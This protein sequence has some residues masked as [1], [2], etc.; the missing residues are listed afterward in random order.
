M[1]LEMNQKTLYLIFLKYTNKLIIM[2]LLLL[3][4]VLLGVLSRGG[5]DK[6]IQKLYGFLIVMVVFLLL[7]LLLIV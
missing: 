3:R 7:G 6:G 4:Q 2:T 1:L 5:M